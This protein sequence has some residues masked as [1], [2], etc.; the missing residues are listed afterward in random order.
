MAM[1]NTKQRLLSCFSASAT[2]PTCFFFEI[3]GS[4]RRIRR[5]REGPI[6]KERKTYNRLTLLVLVF[7]NIMSYI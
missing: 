5:E 6:E 1:I 3:A 4:G 2:T 7:L